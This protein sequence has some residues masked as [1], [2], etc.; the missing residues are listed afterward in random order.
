MLSKGGP[1]FKKIEKKEVHKA[2]KI[3]ML[4]NPIICRLLAFLGEVIWN[5]VLLVVCK[6]ILRNIYFEKILFLKKL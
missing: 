6:I 4:N 1:M 2:F 5:I 3:N